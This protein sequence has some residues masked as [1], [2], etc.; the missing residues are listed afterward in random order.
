MPSSVHA[1]RFYRAAKQRF[2]DALLL[3]EMERTTAAVYLAGY[4]V[5]CMLKALILSAVPQ[6]QAEELL[7]MLH[8]Y[9]E[10]GGA[11]MPAS[12]VPYFARV[13]SWSTDMRYTPGTL[14]AR[15]AK[16]FLCGN[17]NHD[18]GRWAVVTMARIDRRAKPDVQVQQILDVLTEY[19]RSHQQAH[20]EGRRHNPVSIRLRIIDPDFQGM[21][22]IAREPEIWKL[23]SK[24]PE[25]VFVNITMLLLLTPEEAEHSLASQE[26]DHPIPA[27]V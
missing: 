24:L 5:E 17:R 6:T 9:A 18:M 8:L 10:K 1:R 13:N 16:A 27:R 14:T 22:R 21:D 25:E 23:L 15:E 4:S 7:G 11:R 3:L 19:E 20:I 12:V 2:D 26:F